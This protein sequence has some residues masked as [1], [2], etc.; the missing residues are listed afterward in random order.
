MF[1]K[2]EKKEE[3]MGTIIACTAVNVLTGGLSSPFTAR[4]TTRAIN[5]VKK[6]KATKLAIESGNEE[7]IKAVT[8][9]T[10]KKEPT[11]KVTDKKTTEPKKTATKKVVKKEAVKA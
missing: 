2:N 8:A 6:R 10:K 11:N 4:K 7:V 9:S 3:G 5:N 1:S